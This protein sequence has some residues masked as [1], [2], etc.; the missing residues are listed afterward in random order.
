[1]DTRKCFMLMILCC[2]S[3]LAVVRSEYTNELKPKVPALFVFGDSLVD[4]GTNNYL[5]NSSSRADFPPY[6]QNFFHRPTGRF[7]NGRTVFDFIATLLS[8]PF[9]PPFLR[10]GADFSYG[11]NFASGGSGLLE[12]TGKE[13][14]TVPL[15]T[16]IA[17]FKHVTEILYQKNGFNAT[18]LMLSESIYGVVIG[19]NDI[20][21]NYIVNATFQN[22]T[23]PENFVKLLLGQYQKYLLS[24]YETGSRKFIVLDMPPVGC[25]PRFRLAG[26][27]TFNGGCVYTANQLAAAYNVGLKQLLQS[28]N[29]NLQGATLLYVNSFEFVMKLILDGKPYGFS[30]GSSACCGAGPFHTAVECGRKIPKEKLGQFEPFLC[31]N[32]NEFV[33]W[34]AVHPTENVYLKVA[35]NI[36]GGRSSFI[37][38]VNLKTL[39]NQ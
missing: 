30:E 11:A 14:I 20:G 17:Q 37:S 28:L 25:T 18:K 12:S 4:V 22:T 31:K 27:N 35:S 6:G 13:L 24:L 5:A 38:P 2:P 9:A 33:F 39:I 29:N 23:S 36:W 3:V 32:P 19:A 10:P 26:F 7:T 1:M 34:D 21:L 15:A 16:Q 8:L